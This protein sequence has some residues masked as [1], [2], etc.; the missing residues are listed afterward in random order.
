MTKGITKG[1]NIKKSEFIKTYRNPQI[2]GNISVVCSKVGIS[3]QTYYRWLEEDEEFM[4][5]VAN[6][7]TEM[8]D[9][10]EEV[11]YSRG[12]EKDTTALIFWLKNRHPDFKE[13]TQQTNIQ[14]NNYGTKTQEQ[15]D[16]YGI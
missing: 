12:L 1:D 13:T 4:T 8:C 11:L 2:M 3:R 14:V 7:K 9:T 10:A 15:K 6:A 5:K 16:K